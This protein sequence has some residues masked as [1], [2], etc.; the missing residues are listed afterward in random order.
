MF[1]ASAVVYVAS[2]SENK[3]LFKSLLCRM[4]YLGTLQVL[5]VQFFDQ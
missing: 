1:V 3:S 5:I 4:P 2:N